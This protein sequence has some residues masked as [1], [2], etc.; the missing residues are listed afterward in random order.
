[1]LEK[2]KDAQSQALLDLQQELKSLK[3]LLLSRSGPQ[4]PTIPRPGTNFAAAGGT[5]FLPTKPSIPQWQL[6]DPSS[7]SV[8]AISPTIQPASSISEEKAVSSSTT[9]ATVPSSVDGKGKGKED[10]MLNS[11]VLVDSADEDEGVIA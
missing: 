3:A 9:T 6:A 1:M 11:G 10:P 8:T 4:I 7:P 2:H 5:S